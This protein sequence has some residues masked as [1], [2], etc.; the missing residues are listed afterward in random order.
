VRFLADYWWAFAFPL[1]IFFFVRSL[2]RTSR[3]QWVF[4]LRFLGVGLLGGAALWLFTG[5]IQQPVIAL[6]IAGG[7]KGVLLGI[8]AGIAALVGAQRLASRRGP[9]A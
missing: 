1:A 6:H 3:S 2:R 4:I 8:V 7:W 5:D 9:P